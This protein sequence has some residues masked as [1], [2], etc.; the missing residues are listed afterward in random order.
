M[1]PEQLRELLDRI[2]ETP[3]IVLGADHPAAVITAARIEGPLSRWKAAVRE[4]D[5]AYATWREHRTAA[6]YHA[7]RAAT[8]RADA[9]AAALAGLVAPPALLPPAEAG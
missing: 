2:D 7:Y 8:E 6:T 9:A 5:K 4:A 3:A 1:G